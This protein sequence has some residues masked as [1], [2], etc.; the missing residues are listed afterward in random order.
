MFH[1]SRAFTTRHD[2]EQGYA[3][4]LLACT[5]LEISSDAKNEN[6]LQ[7]LVTPVTELTTDQLEVIKGH[8]HNT[9]HLTIS[10]SV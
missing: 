8:S 6:C 1:A 3:F 10:I 2:R 9:V 4:L 5:T 7:N